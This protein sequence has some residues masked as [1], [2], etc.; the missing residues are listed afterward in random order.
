MK[1]WIDRGYSMN[2]LS[3]FINII[4]LS[5]TL[6]YAGCSF[7]PGNNITRT[8]NCMLMTEKMNAPFGLSNDKMEA[9]KEL[10]YLYNSCVQ[11]IIY[12]K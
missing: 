9:L 12:S 8:N 2:L 1:S 4:M 3:K 5:L 6:G 7:I 11:S 10:E